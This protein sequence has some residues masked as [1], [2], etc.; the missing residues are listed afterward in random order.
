TYD[1]L[2]AGPETLASLAQH[3]FA[4]TLRQAQ[5]PMI[6]VGA[7]A[8][9]RA[10]GAAVFSLAAKA[11][12][13]L[14]AVK[15]GWNGFAV[16]HSAASRV[17]ALDLGFVPGR[18]GLTARQMAA[19]GTLDVLF[20]MGADEIDIAPGAFVVYIGTHGD[21]GAN[22]ADVVLPG[23]AYPEK[24]AIYVNTEGRVQMATRAAFPPGDAHED[25]A[26]LRA[27]SDV[28]KNKLP[29][30]SLAALRQA[31]LKAY[32][33]LMRIGQITPADPAAIQAL[34]A[35]GGTADKALFGSSVDDFYFTNPIARASAVMAECSALAQGRTTMT[36]AE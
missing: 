14:G 15:D 12:A 16:L 6:L 18:G 17:G 19:F 3:S 9:A 36:A 22:R 21:R 33:H 8:S 31:L 25:W 32:P 2:G 1:Y 4:D 23:A 5:H 29:Y 28:L 20:L 26:I 7:S 13:E 27:L 10:D 34:A 11:A 24:S 35:L 30:D